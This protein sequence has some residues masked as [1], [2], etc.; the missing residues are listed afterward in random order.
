MILFLIYLSYKSIYSCIN[1][2]Q[3][4]QQSVT[5]SLI[6]AFLLACLLSFQQ[7]IKG[8]FHF[9]QCVTVRNKTVL[10]IQGNIQCYSWWQNIIQIYLFL[11][12]IPLIFVLSHLPFKIKDKNVSV[13]M[14][15]LACVLPVPFQVYLL[16]SNFR[17][18]KSSHNVKQKY[19]KQLP[20]NS[21]PLTSPSE[22]AIVHTLL[23]HYRCLKVRSIRFTWLGIHKIY[24]ILLVVCNTYITEPVQKLCSMI[25]ILLMI[26]LLSSVVKP[27]E[28][29]RAN[30]TASISYIFSLCIAMI[31]LW[32]TALVTF[33]C[34]TNC[35]VKDTYVWYFD[36]CEN[37]LLNWVPIIA[38][39]IWFIYSI[40]E[41]CCIKSKRI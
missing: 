21:L 37:I 17:H 13:R 3:S 35:S 30:I 38:F 31:N 19:K 40:V 15:I 11:N 7:T 33:D 29:N 22:E 4:V 10:Y 25:T 27:Y 39:G 23:V 26:S 28:D 5:A 34:K 20:N 2:C 8:V 6:Q 18:S 41:K 1:R 9:I 12:V 14:F 24:R 16:W 32:K 36:M